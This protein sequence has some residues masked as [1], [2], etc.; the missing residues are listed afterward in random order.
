VT[1][2]VRIKGLP[3]SVFSNNGDEFVWKLL[4]EVRW[5]AQEEA[6]VAQ[7]DGKRLFFVFFSPLTDGDIDTQNNDLN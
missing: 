3:W 7:R 5:C 4:G 2:Y 1:G 6:S